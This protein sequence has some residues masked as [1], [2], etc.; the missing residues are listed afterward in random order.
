MFLLGQFRGSDVDVDADR[1]ERLVGESWLG[2]AWQFSQ[3]YRLSYVVRY[4]TRETKAG[5]ASRDLFWLGFV[6]S[7][8]L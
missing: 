5:P 6:V 2:L 3:E 7:R 8:D 1:V 4:Q